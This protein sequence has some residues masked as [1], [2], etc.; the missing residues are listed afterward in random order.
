MDIEDSN[1]FLFFLHFG[2]YVSYLNIKHE[3]DGKK[4]EEGVVWERVKK[5]MKAGKIT[6]E[7][8]PLA[9]QTELAAQRRE[10][11][12]AKLNADGGT[13]GG[14]GGRRKGIRKRT[15]FAE[16]DAN[17]APESPRKKKKTEAGES[18][19]GEKTGSKQ[20]RH[21]SREH[22]QAGE[23]NSAETDTDEEIPLVR[24]PRKKGIKASNKEGRK[25]EQSSADARK[26]VDGAHKK[27]HAV[28]KTSTR[29]S[30]KTPLSCY[31]CGESGHVPEECPADAPAVAD[32][33]G[34]KQGTVV[35][36]RNETGLAEERKANGTV[37]KSGT[38]ST[39]GKRNEKEQEEEPGVSG[40][41]AKRAQKKPAGE[42][43]RKGEETSGR[44]VA[45][46]RKE[47]SANEEQDAA[48]TENGDKG[49]GSIKTETGDD[50]SARNRKPSRKVVEAKENAK[51]K[52]K[53][54]KEPSAAS[55]AEERRKRA[56]LQQ[57]VDAADA[58]LKL[59][60]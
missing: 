55:L 3:N 6:L 36:E 16:I 2:R 58:L 42:E 9:Y 24:L 30:A 10:D 47:A 41:K 31:K 32:Q 4:C 7:S 28:G 23:E 1:T 60:M 45:V 11:A 26:T 40:A 52:Q 14:K 22:A 33:E 49:T 35:P 51:K 39:D 57:Q 38:E 37:G 48:D 5:L 43:G 27:L 53:A 20:S 56:R 21:G 18:D 8:A 54:G 17:R 13:G 44:S 25:E 12:E 34:I 46:G 29:A 15:E 59:D 50:K 19:Y